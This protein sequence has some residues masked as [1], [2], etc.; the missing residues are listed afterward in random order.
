VQPL[1]RAE[2][3]PRLR[4]HALDRGE[5][6]HGT[7][8]DAEHSLDLGDEIRMAGGVEQV[9]LQVAELERRDRGLDRDAAL[10]FERERVGLRRARVD[11][12]DLRDDARLVE[13]AFGESR[14]TGVYMSQDSKV[15]LLP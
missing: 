13:E 14:L 6:E 3:N 9:D 10:T 4:L 8:E 2:E 12:A 15:E 11:A 5:H 1:E 7:V